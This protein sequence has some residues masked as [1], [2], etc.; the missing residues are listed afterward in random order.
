MF[1][2]EKNCGRLTRGIDGRPRQYIEARLQAN[3]YEN[4]VLPSG[5]KFPWSTALSRRNR[6]PPIPSLHDQLVSGVA[7]ARQH[8]G[9]G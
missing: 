4:A 1:S 5:A 7:A 9:D 6:D 3:R 2:K 8:D